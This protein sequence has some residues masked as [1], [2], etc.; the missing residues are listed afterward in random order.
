[1][2]KSTEENQSLQSLGG[3]ARAEK[4]SAG[5]R[6]DIARR[7]AEARW[8]VDVPDAT[9]EGDFPIGDIVISAAVLPNKKRII[10][11]ATFLRALGRSRSPKAGTGVL[12][13]VD[14]LP[15]FLQAEA[16]KD[17]LDEDLT[18]S[19]TPIFFREKSGKRSVGYD[20]LLLPRVGEVYLKMRDHHLKEGKPVPRQYQ[21]IVAACDMLMRGLAR[22]GIIALVD[23]ATGYQEIRDRLALQEILNKFLRKE[24][25]A[26]ASCFPNEFYKEIFRLRGWTWKGMKVNRPQ[27]VA[28]YTKNLIY[29]RLAPGILKELESR[30][31]IDDK[32]RR[33]TPH[34]F[35]L[36]EDIGHPALAQHL[37]AVIHLMKACD[38]WD[39]MMKMM[40]RSLPPRSECDLFKDVADE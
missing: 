27:C 15:F 12:S 17:F 36:T 18:T 3:L 35:W 22:I 38:S 24:F 21:H 7:G 14:G 13:T 34:Y 25:A 19:T 33:K 39:Q 20:A 16:L 4:L 37:H 5:E 1:M 26:W 29:T 8:G 2:G 28:R 32:G 9:H 6:K 30:N 10:T 40:N 23:E 31:P 11:Q